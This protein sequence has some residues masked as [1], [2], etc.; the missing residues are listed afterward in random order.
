MAT[1]TT[2]APKVVTIPGD[3]LTVQMRPVPGVDTDI[4]VHL[5]RNGARE[6]RF[7]LEEFSQVLSQLQTLLISARARALNAPKAA[8]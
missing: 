4:I 5:T 7:T 6:E 1:I 8:K 3:A 2:P